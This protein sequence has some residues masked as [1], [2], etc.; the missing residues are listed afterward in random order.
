MYVCQVTNDTY[1]CQQF[2]ALNDLLIRESGSLAVFFEVSFF[3]MPFILAQ[4]DALRG[5][6]TFFEGALRSLPGFSRS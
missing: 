5:F 3:F 2:Q 4:N 1:L 6:P